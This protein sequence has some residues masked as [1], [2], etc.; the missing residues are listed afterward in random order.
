MIILSAKAFNQ[1]GSSQLGLVP[2]IKRSRLVAPGYEMKLN[3]KTNQV[4]GLPC[5]NNLGVLTKSVIGGMV[6]KVPR[7]IWVQEILNF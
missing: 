6:A 3:A 5:V 2:P 4:H 7:W 1:L